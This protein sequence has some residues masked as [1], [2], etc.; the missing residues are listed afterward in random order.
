MRVAVVIRLEMHQPPALAQRLDDLR[1]RIE[2]RESLEER[3][4]RDE[5]AVVADRV[6]DRQAVVLADLEVVRAVAGRGVHGAGAGFERHVIAEDDGHFAL[7][8]RML[9]PQ[10]LERLR[11]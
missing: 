10:A 7:V 8:E 2:H 5:A 3:R 4:A 9:E 1:V 11:P 6:V